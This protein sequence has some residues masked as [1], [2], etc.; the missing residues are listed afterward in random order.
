MAA[1]LAADRAAHSHPPAGT[2]EAK[3]MAERF[4]V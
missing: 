2:N 3:K 1:R 4:I